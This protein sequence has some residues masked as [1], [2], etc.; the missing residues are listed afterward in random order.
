[1]LL[2]LLLAVLEDTRNQKL[3]LVGIVSLLLG[4]GIQNLELLQGRGRTVG[5][6]AT[7]ATAAVVIVV[8]VGDGGHQIQQLLLFVVHVHVLI[9]IFV[10][11]VRVRIGV[12][13][14]AS[15]TVDQFA[16]FGFKKTVIVRVVRSH[17]CEI[18]N[19]LSLLQA[20]LC[21][22]QLH[23]CDLSAY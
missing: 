21:S 2:Q 13:G 12:V 23:C 5:A 19:C 1:M 6:T 3:L 15:K 10:V 9:R 17:D 22:L 14:V 7:V 4:L 20:L 18:E 16:G 8:A 11:R